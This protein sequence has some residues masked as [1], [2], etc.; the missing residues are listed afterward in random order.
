MVSW[1]RQVGAASKGKKTMRGRTSWIEQIHSIEVK[2]YRAFLAGQPLTACPYQDGYRNQNGVG[3]GL[4][5][6]RRDAWRRGWT[7]A[8]NDKE[9]W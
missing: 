8:K 9:S 6:Q 3:G 4:Q 2:G 7:S 1:P 5:R